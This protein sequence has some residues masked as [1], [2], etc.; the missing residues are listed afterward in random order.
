MTDIPLSPGPEKNGGWGG[1]FLMLMAL[2]AALATVGYN[3]N[4][5]GNSHPT[6]SPYTYG[7]LDP[8][9]RNGIGEDLLPI[10]RTTPFEDLDMV[11]IFQLLSDHLGPDVQ[12]IQSIYEY[13]DLYGIVLPEEVDPDVFIWDEE[14]ATRASTGNETLDRLISRGIISLMSSPTRGIDFDRVLNE[15]KDKAETIVTTTRSG[16]G[17]TVSADK[18]SITI[19]PTDSQ[20]G[21]TQFWSSYKKNGT[22]SFGLFSRGETGVHNEADFIAHEFFEASIQYFG[23]ENI[24]RIAASWSTTSTNYEI[25]EYYFTQTGDKYFAA[26]QT[27]TGT[28]AAKAGFN[29]VNDVIIQY[30]DY[31]NIRHVDATFT[32]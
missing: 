12:L 6:I 18:E 7:E 25:F 17:I 24:D 30:D 19:K 28:Q 27:W 8:L 4:I 13:R 5:R 16:A 22:I 2:L 21:F 11:Q 1:E 32:R 14:F 9:E 31:G 23:I 29:F 3:A 20:N 26:A 15:A 10:E